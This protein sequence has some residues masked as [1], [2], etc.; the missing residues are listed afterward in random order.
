MKYA[1]ILAEFYNT[2]WLILRSRFD[3]FLSVVEDRSAGGS[4]SAEELMEFKAFAV[5]AQ[6]RSG[7]SSYGAIG[8]LPVQGIIVH[9]AGMVNN[10]S[11]F[12]GVL[13]DFLTV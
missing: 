11:G 2:P 5:E 1:R 3:A 8:V 4:I 9:Y 6:A 13:V 10:M 12:G 7:A